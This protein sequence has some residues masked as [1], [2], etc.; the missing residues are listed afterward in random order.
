MNFLNIKNK[1]LIFET[2]WAGFKQNNKKEY[3]Y[4]FTW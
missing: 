2:S 1:Y 4:L 3:I